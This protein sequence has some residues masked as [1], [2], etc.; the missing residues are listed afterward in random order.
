VA[1]DLRLDLYLVKK[2]LVE[3]RSKSTKL[4][5]DGKITI[6]DKVIKKPSFI[7]DEN[8]TININVDNT[9]N[10][11]SRAGNK[12]DIFLTEL[13]IDIKDFDCLDIGSSTGGFSEVLLENNV[14]S[15]NCVDVGSN[16]LHSKIKSNPKVT[17]N[18]NCDIRNFKSSINFNLITCDVS[19]IS[20]LNILN[21]INYFAKEKII[22]L[23]KP[24]FEVG[25]NVK[26]D[27]KGVVKDEKAINNAIIKFEDETKNLNWSIIKKDISKIKGKEGNVEYFYYFKK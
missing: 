19:F 27:K 1:V 12:L 13:D 25:K 20:I 5:K 15:I 17:V 9:N 7:I 10:Y 22:I 16:Q 11:V 3:N 2:N 18:E 26:R 8:T 24:Q 23:F 21:S 14:K 6:D 4:I